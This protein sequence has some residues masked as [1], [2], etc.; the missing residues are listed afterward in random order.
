VLQGA[1]RLMR[2]RSEEIARIAVL[3]QGKTLA[4]ARMEVGMNV[5]LFEFYAGECYRLYGRVLVRPAG[6][7]STAQ[8]EPSA[9]SRPLHL[10]ISPLAIQAAS[11]ARPSRRAAR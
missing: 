5:G 7:R 1:A 11:W 8:H 3:E 4:E 6:M 2:E 10:G 9:R